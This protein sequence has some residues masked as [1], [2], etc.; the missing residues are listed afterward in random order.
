MAWW[1]WCMVVHAWWWGG[2]CIVVGMV[3]GEPG[4]GGA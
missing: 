4:G 2:A 3:H 1:G